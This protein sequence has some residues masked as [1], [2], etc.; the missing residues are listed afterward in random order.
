MHPHKPSLLII[1]SFDDLSTVLAK[2]KP[3]QWAKIRGV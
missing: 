1:R 2:K 3:L